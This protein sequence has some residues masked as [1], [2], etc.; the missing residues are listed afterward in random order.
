[1]LKYLGMARSMLLFMHVF[2]YILR[3]DSVTG[4]WACVLECCESLE[5]V[6][7][8]ALLNLQMGLRT[9]ALASICSFGKQNSPG[10]ISVLFT[11]LF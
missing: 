2:S 4:H 8:I 9:A 5:M 1:M 7:L 11:Y 3:L 6:E 10:S